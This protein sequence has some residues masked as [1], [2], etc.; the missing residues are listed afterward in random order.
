MALYPPRRVGRVTV[1]AIVGAGPPGLVPWRGRFVRTPVVRVGSTAVRLIGFPGDP[2]VQ[3]QSGSLLFDG[4]W[5][6][7]LS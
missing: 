3:T 4:M 7:L 2:L 6:V 1:I 5:M